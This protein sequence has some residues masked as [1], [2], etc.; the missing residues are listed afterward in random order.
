MNRRESPNEFN[1]STQ[2]NLLKPLF[3]KLTFFQPGTER[4]YP[5]T[6]DVVVDIV[7]MRFGNVVGLTDPVL[8]QPRSP[9]PGLFFIDA[10]GF[11]PTRHH[12]FRVQF[13]K[14]NFSLPLQKFLRSDEVTP[15]ARPLLYPTRL[16]A[17]DSGWDNDYGQNEF[18]SGGDITQT[19]SE[20]QPLELRVPL[21]DFFNAGHRGAPYHFP[22][23]TIASFEKA[24]QLG[25]NG[26]EFDLC[27]TADDHIL[28]FHDAEQSAI[29]YQRRNLEGLPFPIV[30]P[31]FDLV[32]GRMNVAFRRLRGDEYDQTP[33]RPLQS[34]FEFELINLTARE[35]REYFRYR[36]RKGFEFPIP[37]L[38]EFLAF[39]SG[40]TD[41]LRFLFFDIKNPGSS[42]GKEKK[43]MQKFGRLIGTAMKRFTKLPQKMVVCNVVPDYI[44]ELRAGFRE[45]TEDRVEFAYDAGAALLKRNPVRIANEKKTT[46][47]SI[48]AQGRPGDLNDVIKAARRRDYPEEYKNELTN[49]RMSTVVHW[50]LNG[51]N[52]IIES[53]RAGVNGILTDKPEEMWTNLAPLRVGP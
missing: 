5:V 30:S 18:F 1:L 12:F 19:T 52:E 51:R 29:A 9:Q 10:P 43:H 49:T 20:E 3:L 41:R 21:R 36:H 53:F 35:V 44:D 38:E 33:W 45:S 28:I 4:E 25:A 13:A 16:P 48:G 6:D 14:P 34:P 22:E 8:L 7:P 26:F 32:N 27:L 37:D 39:C 50:T 23:N 17:W 46:V 11:K 47:I 31:V 40:Q 42:N 15:Q 24:L 2:R